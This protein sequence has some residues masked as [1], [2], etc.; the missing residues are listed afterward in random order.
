VSSSAG[1]RYWNEVADDWP[2][3]RD[4]LWRMHAD[5]VN[6]A[7]CRRGLPPGRSGRLLKT[8]AFDE[9][10]GPGLWP[11]LSQLAG[12]VEVIDHAR[13]IARSARRRHPGLS[14]TGADVRNLPFADAVFDA[15]V[16][17]STLDHF[18]DVQEI[19]RSVAELRRVLRPGGRLLLTLDNAAHPFVRLRNALP[20]S[21]LRR[22]GLVPYVV[23]ATLEP[24]GT[25]DL[26]RGA[27]FRVLEVTAILHCP[28]V[29][30]VPLAGLIDR[31]GPQSVVATAF[32]RLLRMCE[33]AARW[34]TRFRTGHYVAVL[35][36]KA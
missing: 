29:L 24:A 32:L 13:T 30:A 11:M 14:A 1:A 20:G 6:A 19:Q 31:L 34:P 8:D 9:A 21:W 16:S 25:A 28:R 15:V 23:G 3:G 27:G 10:V 36:E 18:D 26:V 5:A 22:T 35:A 12:R 17:N 2:A 7:W 33:G 4:R